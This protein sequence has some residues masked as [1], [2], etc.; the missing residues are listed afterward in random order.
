MG[1]GKSSVGREVALQMGLKF[2]DTDKMIEARAGKS[3]AQIFAEKGEI[4]FRE[5][6]GK[7]VEQLEDA[8]GLVIAT[9]GGLPARQTNIDSLKTHALIVCLWASAE[10]IWLRVHRHSHRPLLQ[11]PNP[12]AT[13]R[14]LIAARAPF[15]RQADVLLNTD[16]RS[17]QQVIQQVIREFQAACAKAK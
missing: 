14:E 3:I 11:T 10:K 17:Q 13:I 16:N 15:Y 8:S 6:E 2:R 12:K 4:Y 1:V 7:V 9:G 5:I